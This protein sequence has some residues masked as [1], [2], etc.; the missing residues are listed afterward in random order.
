[1]ESFW[2][3]TLKDDIL[4]PAGVINKQST[5]L[6]EMTHN[7]VRLEVLEYKPSYTYYTITKDMCDLTQSFASQA[8][9]KVEVKGDAI[10]NNEKK[11]NFQVNII[12]TGVNNFKYNIM[13]FGH[14]ISIYPVTVELNQDVQFEEDNLKYIINTFDDFCDFL[15]RL[16]NSEKIK[17][18]I[19]NLYDIT[20]K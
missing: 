10:P 1:M 9:G 4:T 20:Q 14:T 3:F 12:T 7:K 11:M 16:F 6:E 8:L 13:T 17:N 18:V 15:K 2:G 19:Q 5:F